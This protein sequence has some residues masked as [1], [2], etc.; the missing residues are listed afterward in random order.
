M[1]T[2]VLLWYIGFL[3]LVQPVI[4][5]AQ[6]EKKPARIYTINNKTID[7]FIKKPIDDSS[8]HFQQLGEWNDSSSNMRIP[9]SQ[10]D[11]IEVPG[12]GRSLM[13][14]VLFGLGTGALGGGILGFALPND[15]EE[16][17]WAVP[18]NDRVR[19]MAWGAAIGTVIGLG[20]GLFSKES[21][22]MF[23]M[24]RRHKLTAKQKRKLNAVS[25]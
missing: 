20:F 3:L 21:N 14:R 5:Q 12:A 13:G 10:I 25:F 8:I 24:T 6:Q 1:K 16:G 2:S 18:L 23:V 11:R 9:V 22:D 15:D 7:G 4:A 17:W 19:G